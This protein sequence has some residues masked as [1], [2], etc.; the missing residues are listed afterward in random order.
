MVEKSRNQTEKQIPTGQPL[1]QLSRPGRLM[2]EVGVTIRHPLVAFT[3]GGGLGGKR[4]T[5][6]E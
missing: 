3:Y 2:H 6:D 1:T 5:N 4:G